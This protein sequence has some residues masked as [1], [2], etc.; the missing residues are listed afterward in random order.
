MIKIN[1]QLTK[2]YVACPA[3]YA[4][5]GPELLHQLANQLIKMGIQAFMLYI[6]YGSENPVHPNY[7]HYKVPYATQVEN[8][9]ENI[10]II[11]EAM[12]QLIFDKEISKMRQVIWWL[13]VDNFFPYIDGLLQRHSHKKMFKLKQLLFNYY[14]IPT[15][16]YIA[17]KRKFY[18]LSQSAYATDFLKNN[19][20]HHVAYL[21]DYLNKAFLSKSSSSTQKERKN[22]VLYNPKKGL[23]FTK[24]LIQQAPH[25]TFVPIENMSPEQVSELLSSSKVYIDF[26]NHPGKDRFPREAAIM[27][28]C[29]ITNKKGSA[30]F[31]ED[32]PIND[33]FKFGDRIDDIPKIVAKIDNCL[34]NYNQE[35]SKF[36][37]YREV[38]RNEEQKFKADLAKIFLID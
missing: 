38:I 9:K 32:V 11:P 2:I 18:H 34:E 8:S 22:V 12:P 33:E 36:N 15:V 19:N 5:G 35:Q 26:G 21:S 10:V 1:Q 24:L 16:K 17:S 20:I 14:K 28:C 30:N 7:E 31:F 25:I 13:S 37:H 4:T 6:P 23:E 3:N 29:I 27:G